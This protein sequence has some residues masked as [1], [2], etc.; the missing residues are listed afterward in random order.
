MMK[1]LHNVMIMVVVF[2]SLLQVCEGC[3][4]SSCWEGGSTA[5]FSMESLNK[6]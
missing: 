3:E 1:K 4:P 6:S 5:K 2:S